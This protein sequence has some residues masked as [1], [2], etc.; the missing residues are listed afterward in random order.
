MAG[1]ST[2]HYAASSSLETLE[3]RRLAVES[4]KHFHRILKV[5]HGHPS[6]LC[7]VGTRRNR[8]RVVPLNLIFYNFEIDCVATILIST[9]FAGAAAASKHTE[10]QL[11][12]TQGL[13]KDA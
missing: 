2:Q 4:L 5:H 11:P 9:T 3:G 13:Q 7:D 8:K 12:Q 1:H 6:S 10:L